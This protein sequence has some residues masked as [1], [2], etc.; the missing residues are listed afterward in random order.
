M[1]TDAKDIEASLI[2]QLCRHD[3]FGQ[4]IAGRFRPAN[5]KG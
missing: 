4:P 2:G 1:L 3:D 5:A